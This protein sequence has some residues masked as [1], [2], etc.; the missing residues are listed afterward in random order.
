MRDA[1]RISCQLCGTYEISGTARATLRGEHADLVPYLS[2]YTRQS[3]E[4]EG[5]AVQ[6]VSNWPPLAEVHQHTSV[7]QRA[8]KLLRAIEKRTRQPGEF[9]SVNT[10]L[11]Y[12]LIDAVN[13]EPLYYFL[14]HWEDLGCIER[15]HSN[16]ARL[17]VKGWDR[18]DPGSAGAGIPGR[19]FIAM[20]FD[21]SLDEVYEHGIKAAVEGDCQMTPI[22]VDKVHY[23][24]KICDR[25]LA[26]IRRSQFMVADFTD[27]KAGVYF[28]AGFALG[29]G[30]LVIWTCREDAIKDAHFD[31]RQYPHLVWK[32]AA[33]FREKLAE[34]IQA[35]FSR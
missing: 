15:K 7:H 35:L 29:L 13:A 5:R 18:L 11:D 22:R 28:E 34:R 26:E 30:R 31:T 17:T 14:K 8:E 6:L 9:I 12:P 25:I 16:V 27:H 33:D 24:E 4:F 1:S 3:W 10:E 23:T 32:D 20:S 2:A 21:A 19:V